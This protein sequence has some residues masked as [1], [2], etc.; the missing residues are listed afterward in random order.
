MQIT[1]PR[2]E[3]DA[4]ERTGPFRLQN[5]GWL[6][7]TPG[8]IRADEGIRGIAAEESVLL[9]EPPYKIQM[10]ISRNLIV[11]AKRNIALMVWVSRGSTIW[12]QHGENAFLEV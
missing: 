8:C 4:V 6:N 1:K 7:L 5:V 11:A 12:I 10:I 2:V 9:V 3:E